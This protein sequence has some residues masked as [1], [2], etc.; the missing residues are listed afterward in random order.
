MDELTIAQDYWVNTTLDRPVRGLTP[1]VIEESKFL[2]EEETIPI[3]TGTVAEIAPLAIE[4]VPIEPNA[5]AI[6]PSVV[7]VTEIIVAPP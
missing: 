1:P 5:A 4:S 7:D 6:D 2:G 3:A